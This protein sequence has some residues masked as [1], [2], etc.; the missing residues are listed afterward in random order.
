MEIYFTK[1][2]EEVH[3]KLVFATLE[4]NG[5]GDV[6]VEADRKH[7][8][9]D[10]EEHNVQGNGDPPTNARKRMLASSNTTHRHMVAGRQGDG[11]DEGQKACK[12]MVTMR[13]RIESPLPMYVMTI[14]IFCT[15]SLC[16]VICVWA[17]QQSE[18]G[19]MITRTLDLAGVGRYHVTTRC[20]PC[21]DHRCFTKMSAK[22]GDE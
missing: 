21:S 11:E 5:D 16:K 19:E 13:A 10:G 9:K 17:Y 8:E 12:A 14:E 18:V 2:H 20:R 3:D 6:H 7:G 1:G 4:D 15:T 22:K